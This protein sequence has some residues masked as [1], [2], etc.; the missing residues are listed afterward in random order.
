[1]AV[2]AQGGY[3]RGLLAP[4][5]DIDLLFLLPYKQTAWGESVAEYMLYLL[6]DLGFKVG[7]ATR[8]I[9]QCVRLSHSDM[10]I[11]TALLD[12][13]LILGDEALCSPI[14]STA[15]ARKCS[16]AT[17]G[18]SSRRSSPSRMRA[19]RAPAPRA[20][21]SSP[22]SR[23]AKAACAICTPC[24]GSPSTSIPTRP[25]PSSSRPACSRAHE[26]RSFRR[27]ESFLWTVRCDLHFLTGRPE[28][29]LCFDLQ[30]PMAERL[31]YRGHA[32][33]ERG[34]ALHA[35]LFP[36]RQGG[37]RAD[38]HRLLGA[39]DEAAEVAARP[40]TRCSPRSAGAAAPSS[41]ARRISASRTAASP[42]STRTPSPR[43][44]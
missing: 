31:G 43:T 21:W 9:D 37:R 35:A 19:M 29:R 18:R 11:R 16:K 24:T 30:Q 14:S 23:T 13:R 7:H 4:G 1:M 27:C 3:G 2:V 32:R 25:R 6:W 40:S 22:T 36:G 15:S 39:R 20:I 17:R 5:S 34:R 10:T 41:G 8:N 28:E 12:A 38:R 44:R 33:L 42:P 26:Y